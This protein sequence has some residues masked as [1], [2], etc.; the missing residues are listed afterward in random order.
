MTSNLLLRLAAV[1]LA[2]VA[3]SP[4]TFAHC[5]TLDGPVVQAARHALDRGD[6]TPVLKWI[7]V[8]EE[9]G[10]Q[11]AFAQT[12]AVRKLS[13]AAAELA[14]RYFFETLVR[15]HRAGEGVPYTGLQPAGSAGRALAAADQAIEQEAFEPL[16]RDLVTRLQEQLH[17]QFHELLAAK[18]HRDDSVAAGRR[19]IEAYVS[20]IHR[21]ERL[22]AETGAASTPATVH[23][24]H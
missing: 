24:Q 12:L 8:G 15:I 21:Y 22:A 18:A 14:D 4:V 19:Y 5:D 3:S 1:S 20:F 23:H 2:L 7:P 11:A 13:P 10:I 16:A 17:A 6:V 9:A